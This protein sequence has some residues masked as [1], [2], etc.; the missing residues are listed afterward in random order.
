MKLKLRILGKRM[1]K[2]RFTLPQHLNTY[3]L[4]WT[5]SNI[6]L[7]S[8]I[9]RY[10]HYVIYGEMIKYVLCNAHSPFWY[11]KPG[12]M[13]IMKLKS[14]WYMDINSDVVIKVW[15]VNNV[16]CVWEQQYTCFAWFTPF[17]SRVTES[18]YKLS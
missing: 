4:P 13:G 1:W 9:F 12:I 3:I 11:T 7:I 18:I 5:C 14:V 10:L 16:I 15:E 17:S 8:I 2:I 6:L